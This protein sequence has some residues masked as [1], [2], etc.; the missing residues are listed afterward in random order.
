MFIPTLGLKP[1]YESDEANFPPSLFANSLLCQLAET[2]SIFPTA[3][4]YMARKSGMDREHAHEVP[5]FKT[6][7][8]ASV[9]NYTTRL[10]RK[11]STG[12][13]QSVRSK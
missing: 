9:E 7:N 6:A 4:S 2:T 8:M 3:R 10:E 12:H 11:P 1:V 13:K 5:D